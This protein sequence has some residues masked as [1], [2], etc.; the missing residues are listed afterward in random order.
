MGFV[1]FQLKNTV[2]LRIRTTKLITNEATKSTPLLQIPTYLVIP[3]YTRKYDDDDDTTTT[4]T[5]TTS[6]TTIANTT[7]ASGSAIPIASTTYL[8]PARSHWSR[9]VLV[10]TCTR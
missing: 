4:T 2:V 8:Y 3:T 7:T 5:N 10:G 9:Y 1:V 6:A